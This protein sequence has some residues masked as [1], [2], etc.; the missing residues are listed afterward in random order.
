MPG[1]VPGAP[2]FVLGIRGLKT[3]MAGT[4]PANGYFAKSPAALRRCRSALFN[5]RF[6]EDD[7]LA[8]HGV[9]LLE[10][11]LIRL[12]PRVL[13]RH[14]EKA[15][16]GAADELDQD[17][18]GFRHGGSRGFGSSAVSKI[19]RGRPLSRRARAGRPGPDCAP[20]ERSPAA[21][22]ARSRKAADPTADARPA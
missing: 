16:I 19:V 2:V 18:A 1:L 10:L 8:R 15:G 12:G 14:V 17:G 13:L 3:R 20:P 6:A 22:A 11:E 21:H 5:L 9:E 4:S 7:V